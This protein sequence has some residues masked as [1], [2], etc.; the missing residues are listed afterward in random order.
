[1]GEFFSHGMGPR[2]PILRLSFLIG[3][4][5][6]C[7]G[8]GVVG[9]TFEA[10]SRPCNGGKKAPSIQPFFQPRFSASMSQNVDTPAPLSI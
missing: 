6:A 10:A 5:F 1:M 9:Y 7:A 4:E 8:V 3:L 2:F